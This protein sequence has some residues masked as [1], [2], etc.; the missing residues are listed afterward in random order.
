MSYLLPHLTSGW[1]VDQAIL[2]E[3]SRVRTTNAVRSSIPQADSFHPLQVVVMRFG[4]DSD[5]VCMQMDE[6]LA[7]I[8]D[9][10]KQFAVIYL[11]DIGEVPDFTEMYELYDPMTVMFFYRNKASAFWCIRASEFTGLGLSECPPSFSARFSLC[12]SI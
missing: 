1:A 5:P 2:T 9:D 3:E 7:D 8:S 4:R 10:V 6:S 11:V 12:C